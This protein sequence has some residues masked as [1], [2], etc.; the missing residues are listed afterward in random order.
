MAPHTP[1]RQAIATR[2]HGREKRMATATAQAA[3]APRIDL[4]KRYRTVRDLSERLCDPL[5]REDYVVQSMPDASPAKWHLAHT[6]WFFETFVLRE[7]VKDYKPFCPE[8][9]VLF[10]SYYNRIGAQ[11]PRPKR[12]LLSRPTVPEVYAYRRHVDEAMARLLR[13]DSIGSDM[14]RVIEVGLN[15]EQQ[16][17]EL[18][19]TDIKHLFS[20]NPLHPAY[21]ATSNP[22][23][24][25]PNG[26]FESEAA[27]CDLRWVNFD[28]GIYETGYVGDGFAYD[29][30]SPRHGVLLR[31]FALASR[32]A[33]NAEYLEFIAD[34]GYE[35]P[36]LWLSEGWA[37]VLEQSWKAPLYWA[38]EN[39]ACAQMTLN[40]C[41]A[42]VPSEPVCHVSY[43]EADAF[44][45]WAGARLPLEQEWEIVAAGAQIRG[46]FV[47]D[48]RLHPAS[49]GEGTSAGGGD[50][51]AA[52]FGRRADLRRCLGMDL[53]SLHAL[54]GLS[55][56]GQRPR[57]IQRKVYVQSVRVARRFLCHF[58]DTYPAHLPKLFSAGRPLAVQR[59]PACQ[60]RIK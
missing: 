27:L 14:A 51:R 44:A 7:A 32:L 10:N 24:A 53:K 13:N 40:G 33:T 42:V 38:F 49:A 57:R 26:L 36:E 23:H 31:P 35:R 12:G 11:F 46:N 2:L 39:G 43:Y 16:H 50:E 47:E 41:R 60:G 19:L 5:E 17:Q 52:G 56:R 1:F 30:E 9:A 59:H 20:L 58:P 48:G 18:I 45:R 15:H 21:T 54:S 4:E 8:Y 37:Q 25:S 6:T 3:Q 29:N 28:G 34:G 55:R 22:P